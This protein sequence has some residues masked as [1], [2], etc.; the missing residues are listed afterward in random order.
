MANPTEKTKAD[1]TEWPDRDISWCLD[2]LNAFS[3]EKG[4]EEGDYGLFVGPF[5]TFPDYWMYLHFVFHYFS[6]GVERRSEKWKGSGIRCDRRNICLARASEPVHFTEERVWLGMRTA[7]PYKGEKTG[8]NPSTVAFALSESFWFQI[9][10]TENDWLQS[11]LESPEAAA[12][13]ALFQLLLMQGV[14]MWSKSWTD[15]LNWVDTFHEV[16]VYLD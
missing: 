5:G 12:G 4:P 1:V 3:R 14:D 13:V 9:N 8:A 7:T 16:Q 11:G 10:A 6:P 15:S 2:G